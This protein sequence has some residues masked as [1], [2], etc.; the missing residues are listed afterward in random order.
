MIYKVI[1]LKNT[2]V[3][4]I[5]TEIMFELATE[6]ASGTELVRLNLPK[7]LD[8]Q[9][10]KRINLAVRRLLRSMK[11]RGAIQFF[12]NPD[13]FESAGM[14]SRFL[15]NKYTCVFENEELSDGFVFVK[16]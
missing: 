3:G 15:L 13:N 8:M 1:N 9:S 12:A 7:P 11:E 4:Q 14:E 10:E 16:L 2:E 6:R 5:K